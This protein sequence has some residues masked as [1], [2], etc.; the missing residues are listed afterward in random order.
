[1]TKVKARIL[2]DDIRNENSRSGL[3]V[4][5]DPDEQS[6]LKLRKFVADAPFKAEKSTGFHVT[7]LYHEDD[8]PFGVKPPIDRLCTG[9]LD[10]VTLLIDHKKRPIVIAHIDSDDLQRLHREL[11]GEGLHHSFDDYMVHLTLCYEAEIT[12]QL[13]LWIEQ[14]NQDLEQQPIDLAFGPQLKAEALD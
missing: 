7:V 10:R 8:L 12:A 11:L 14:K 4:W 6:V 2:Y 5:I 3:Y 1:V 13:R 9:R